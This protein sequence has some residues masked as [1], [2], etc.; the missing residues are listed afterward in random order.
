MSS[1]KTRHSRR[2]PV[3]VGAVL[4][5]GLLAGCSGAG[6]SAPTGTAGTGGGAGAGGGGAAGANPGTSG[7]TG[8]AGACHEEPVPAWDGG[9][10]TEGGAAAACEACERAH[11]EH[12]RCP[13]NL[14][15]ATHEED[16]NSGDQVPVGWGLTTLATQ[17]E[18]D[19]GAALL[20]CLNQRRCATDAMNL[21]PGDNPSLGCF[22]GP[23]VAPIDCI[24]GDGVHGV[25]LAEY[26]AAAR[27]T[28]GGPP[29]G[30]SRATLSLYVSMKA[31][32]PS[33]PIG[34]ADMI[35]RCAIAVG[36]AACFEL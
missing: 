35:N 2:R 27:A 17:A 4:T 30:A 19:A 34:L 1:K 7:T 20:R 18:R 29:S 28:P 8:D 12:D 15:T 14:L 16:P 24:T 5:L 22:C 32:D 6:T 26:E 33:G 9:A 13:P 21:C 23:D 36:C 3:L 11:A 31:Y 10:P 25:C